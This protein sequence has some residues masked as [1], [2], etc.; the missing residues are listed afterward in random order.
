MVGVA[1]EREAGAVGGGTRVFAEGTEVQR[2][3]ALA[4]ATAAA[5][6]EREG[7]DD[8]EAW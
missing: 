7:E 1:E 5:R 3:A 2:R 4:A 6:G 8:D